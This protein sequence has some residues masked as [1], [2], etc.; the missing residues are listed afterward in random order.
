[1]YLKFTSGKKKKN[2]LPKE[3]KAL[4]RY[5]NTVLR[6]KTIYNLVK[7]KKIE[8]SFLADWFQKM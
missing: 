2:F 6:N 3:Y 5:T 7:Q 4:C 8:N 1:M